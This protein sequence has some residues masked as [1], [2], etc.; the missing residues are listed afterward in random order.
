MRTFTIIR[1]ANYF[2]LKH[3]GKIILLME[4]KAGKILVHS[5]SKD[6]SFSRRVDE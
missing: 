3:K 6:V 1:I 4:E 2:A 5:I